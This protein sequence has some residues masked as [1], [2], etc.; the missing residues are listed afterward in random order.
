M[1]VEPG[2]DRLKTGQMHPDK[3]SVNMDQYAPGTANADAQLH[4]T[5]AAH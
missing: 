5:R 4:I 1:R 2:L 3:D